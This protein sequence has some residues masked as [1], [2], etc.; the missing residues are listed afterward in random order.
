MFIHSVAPHPKMMIKHNKV[1]KSRMKW[2]ITPPKNMLCLV[3]SGSP[4][5]LRATKAMMKPS[6]LTAQV[7]IYQDFHWVTDKNN[8]L[9]IFTEAAFPANRLPE[10]RKGGNLHWNMIKYSVYAESGGFKQKCWVSIRSD[11]RS[12]L[13]QSASKLWSKWTLVEKIQF[14]FF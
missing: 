1:E 2:A 5:V 3:K 10:R 12:P 9:P 6:G 8:K 11:T 7:W 14:G 4:P 13:I